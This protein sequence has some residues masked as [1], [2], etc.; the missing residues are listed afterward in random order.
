MGNGTSSNIKYDRF[1]SEEQ[2]E[3]LEDFKLTYA[4]KSK[5]ELMLVKKM[6]KPYE[7]VIYSNNYE[8]ALKNEAHLIQFVSEIGRPFVV[9]YF[10]NTYKILFVFDKNLK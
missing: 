10:E 8:I 4:D 9:A 3:I 2:L 5:K 6:Y 1:T 7:F